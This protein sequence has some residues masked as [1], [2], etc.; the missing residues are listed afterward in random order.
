VKKIFLNKNVV[1]TGSSTGLGYSLGVEYLKHGANVIFCGNKNE[2]NFR[3]LKGKFLNKK[4]FFL[5]DFLEERE[6]TNFKKLVSLKFKKID[7]LIHCLGGGF[8]IT[9]KLPT[10]DQMLKLYKLNFGIGAE[11]NRILYPLI[12]KKYGHI[13]HVGSTASVQA[14]GSVGYTSMKTAIRGYVKILASKLISEGIIVNSFMP[15]AFIA[16]DN[17]FYRMKNNDPK[18][19]KKFLNKLKV[20]EINSCKNIIPLIFLMSSEQGRMLAGS[21]ILIDSCE[22]NAI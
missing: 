18:Y 14:I 17:H 11:I 2:K 3:L 10:A 19:Y 20:P 15:G 6:F 7:I 4:F 16:K 12:K 21:N 1:I 22:T 8:G 13:I 9:D 5:G